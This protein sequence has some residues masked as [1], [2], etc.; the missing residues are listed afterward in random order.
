MSS[1]PSSTETRRAKELMHIKS[2]E[3]AHP[4]DIKKHSLR[5]FAF[6]YPYRCGSVSLMVKVMDSWLAHREF[7][8]NAAEDPPYRGA[9]VR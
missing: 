8:P 9:D 4:F 3:A 7:K 5:P 6:F 1:S 2:I